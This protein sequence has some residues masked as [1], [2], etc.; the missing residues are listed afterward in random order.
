M[1]CG[2]GHGNQEVGSLLGDDNP[3][4]DLEWLDPLEKLAGVLAV[5]A[6]ALAASAVA[7]VD[8]IATRDA[9]RMEDGAGVLFR[10]AGIVRGEDMLAHE[11]ARLSHVEL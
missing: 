8:V 2:A 6:G 11:A 9:V 3:I 4:P 7:V 1:T 10:R 5:V